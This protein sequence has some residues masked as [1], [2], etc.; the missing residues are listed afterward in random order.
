MNWGK[1]LN[2]LIVV[3][4]ILNIILGSLN[5]GKNIKAYIMTNSSQQDVIK[6]LESKNIL[7]TAS[8]PRIAVPMSAVWIMPE[9]I[10]LSKREEMV[11]AIL[12]QNGV[13]ISNK[14]NKRYYTKELKQLIFDYNTMIYTNT[15][16]TPILENID[17]KKAKKEADLFLKKL[18]L[19]NNFKRAKVSCQQEE[20]IFTFTYYETINFLPV[21]NSYV[22]VV[23]SD[24]GVIY[25]QVN[26]VKVTKADSAK[27]YIYPA[28]KVLFGIEDYLESSEKP[29]VITGITLGYGVSDEKTQDIFE[30]EAVPVYKIDILNKN[31]PIY[32]NAYTNNLQ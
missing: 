7:V 16:G 6:M 23:V 18:S 19:G 14:N 27:Q 11:K 12:G 30:E 9:N 32:I 26:K 1:I 28:D 15:E 3:F 25:A 29:V 31:E 8:V 21:F 24:K 2:K 13:A 10:T 5:F 20:N 4:L 22:K 17:E